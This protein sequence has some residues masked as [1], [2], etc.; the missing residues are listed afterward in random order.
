MESIKES[1]SSGFFSTLLQKQMF[2][3]YNRSLISGPSPFAPRRA[4]LRL[5]RLGL[6]NPYQ[7]LCQ[8]PE[9]LERRLYFLGHVFLSLAV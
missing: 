7:L 2:V 3:A 4:C 6:W 1:G 8:K 5:I 9:P